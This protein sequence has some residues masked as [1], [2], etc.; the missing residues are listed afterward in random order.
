M[1]GW[2]AHVCN[3]DAQCLLRHIE[4]SHL[5]CLLIQPNLFRF[6]ITREGNVFILVYIPLCQC[7]IPPLC[8]LLFVSVSFY[9]LPAFCSLFVFYFLIFFPSFFL[10]ILFLIFVFLHLV[11]TTLCRKL[12]HIS[13]FAFSWP[14]ALPPV[15]LTS[16]FLI[17]WDD[18]ILKCFGNCMCDCYWSI[19]V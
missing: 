11:L 2:E 9:W 17:S 19:F 5:L 8:P 4:W 13:S 12:F 18:S 15:P 6:L 14:S 7:N 16:E 1:T 3:G 10:V